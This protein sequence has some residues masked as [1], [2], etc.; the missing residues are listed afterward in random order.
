MLGSLDLEAAR[1]HAGALAAAGA[2]LAR[3]G[4]GER[5]V[6]A[7]YQA[8]LV[9]DVRH[10]PAPARASRRG[11]G[12]WIAL[13]VAGEAVEARAL[14]VLDAAEL[15]ALEAVGLLGRDGEAVT[16][17][18][19]VV[20]VR[21]VLVAADRLDARSPQAVGSPD[22][23]AWNLAASLP[24][25]PATLLD[26]GTGAGTAALIAARA[27]ARVVGT[28]IDRRAVEMAVVNALLNDVRAVFLEGDLFAGV[29][30]R[31]EVVCFNAPLAR[32]ELAIAGGAPLYSYSPRG[33]KLIV[34]FLAGVRARVAD[35][36]EALC[37]AQLTLGVAAAAAGAGFPRR[38]EVH[39][40]DAPDGTPH[41]LASLRS[42]GAP[43][44]RRFRVPLGPAC[45]HLHRELIDRLHAAADL[46]AASDEALAAATVRP[47][48]WLSLTRTAVHD[49]AAFRERD[50][51]FGA[52]RL[53][54]DELALLEACDGRPVAA[55]AADAAA[56]EKVR[57][58]VARGLL[59]P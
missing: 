11:L 35:G 16:A 47:P 7:W 41:A 10:L 31:F 39:F 54:A 34:D 8:P 22:V 18:V 32:A 19:S 53:D 57:A 27:G 52:H 49:G 55:L 1:R 59:V 4:F 14:G 48:P 45:P 2:K 12:G 9:S 26:V 13:L 5:M 51:R 50:L 43:A 42:D 37:H 17:R 29:D 3:A 56:R 40:A 46:A 6:C 38:I 23:S 58:L 30:D 28:D 20:P 21:G 33:E 44:Y 36:G 15:A 25:R 24:A